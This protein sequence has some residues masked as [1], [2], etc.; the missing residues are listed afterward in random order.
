VAAIVQQQDDERARRKR[1]MRTA[2]V[3]GLVAL[4]FYVGFIVISVMR[5]QP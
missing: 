4:A 5:S 2:V 1:V 3:L